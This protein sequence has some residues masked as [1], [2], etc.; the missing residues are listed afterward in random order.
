MAAFK[1]SRTAREKKPDNE[2]TRL[3]EK[4][5]ALQSLNRQEKNRIAEICYGTFGSRFAGYKLAGW[6]WYL[7]GCLNQYVVEFNYGHLQY[8]WAADKTALRKVLRGVK[9]IIAC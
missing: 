1:F 7:H 6:C 5:M 9:K 4:A 2:I 3:L 8:H